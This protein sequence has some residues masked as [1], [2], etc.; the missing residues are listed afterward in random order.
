[1]QQSR[2]QEEEIVIMVNVAC[3]GIWNLIVSLIMEKRA[4]NGMQRIR[5]NLLQVFVITAMEFT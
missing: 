5:T 3:S 1:M 2:S 4:G